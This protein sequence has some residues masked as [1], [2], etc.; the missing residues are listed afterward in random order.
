MPLFLLIFLLPISVFSGLFAQQ[1]FAPYQRSLWIQP[2]AIK[3]EYNNPFLPSPYQINIF[4]ITTQYGITDRLT[5]DLTAGFGKIFKI[6]DYYP[7][8]GIEQSNPT[9]TK[10]GFIDTRFGLRYKILDEFDSK[11]AWL[12]TISLRLGGIK[13]GDYDRRPQ[14]LGDGASGIEA[15]LYFAKDFQFWNLGTFGEMGYRNREK[16]VP[17]DRIYALFLYK[18]FFEDWF[19]FVGM[20]GQTSLAGTAFADPAQNE[21]Q[22]PS[23]PGTVRPIPTSN[24]GLA[25]ELWLAQERPDWAR[26]E[27]FVRHE[28]SLGYKD[29][30]GNFYTV[31]YSKTVQTLNSPA[32][33][34]IGLLANFSFYL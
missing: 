15:N 19:L 12:P 29:S 13:K 27:N 18:N 30:Y 9:T 5:F 25:Q 7:L 23:P 26:R 1:A 2:T 32:L 10:Q 4:Q 8:A 3:S 28:A 20:R 34:T 33:E 6:S 22:V 16:P 17:P 21:P 24:E 11:I 14:S 31:F